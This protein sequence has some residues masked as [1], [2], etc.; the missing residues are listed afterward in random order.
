MFSENWA[1][2][3]WS[4]DLS[5]K[6]IAQDLGIDYVEFIEQLKEGKNDIDIADKFMVKKEMISQLRQQFER[7]GLDSIQGQD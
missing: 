5:L 7:F 4:S 3:P 1:R 6:D 2:V